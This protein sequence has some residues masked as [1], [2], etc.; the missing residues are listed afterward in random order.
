MDSLSQRILEQTIE[1]DN[2]NLLQYEQELLEIEKNLQQKEVPLNKQ[3]QVLQDF[4]SFLQHN[5]DEQTRNKKKKEILWLYVDYETNTLKN[6]IETPPT[7]GKPFI[8]YLQEHPATLQ[9][10][11][12]YLQEPET[13]ETWS[14]TIENIW[15]EFAFWAMDSQLQE[16]IK[17]EP[18][19]LQNMKT[20]LSLYFTDRLNG[21]SQSDLKKVSQV[22]NWRDGL[23]S[24]TSDLLW[25]FKNLTSFRE[26]MSAITFFTEG[27]DIYSKELTSDPE[28]NMSNLEAFQSP[29]GF[30]RLLKKHTLTP[31]SKRTD[32]IWLFETY[33]DINNQSQI[34]SWSIIEWLADSYT[35]NAHTLMTKVAILWPK[36]LES[37]SALKSTFW[38]LYDQI[39]QIVSIFN[40]GKPLSEVIKGS[41][42]EKPLNFIASILWFGSLTRYESRNNI[43][44]LTKKAP[45]SQKAW[46]L[47]AIDFV[48]QNDSPEVSEAFQKMFN[49][50]KTEDYTKYNITKEQVI[51]Q[52]PSESVLK[53]GI[54]R[55][56]L[57]DQSFFIHPKILQEISINKSEQYY[58]TDEKGNTILNPQKISDYQKIVKENLTTIC[59]HVWLWKKWLLNSDTIVSMVW[60]WKTKEHITSYLLTWL[61]YPDTALDITQKNIS[62][63]KKEK[64]D[65]E[66]INIQK[67]KNGIFA[68][69]SKN[70]KDPYKAENPTSSA[71]GKYQFLWNTRKEKITPITGISDKETYKNS[72]EQQEKFMDYV[73]QH[74][75][76]PTAKK[77]QVQ[78][79]N[80]KLPEL[81]MLLHFKWE[82]GTLDWIKN[83]VDK[84]TA[85]NI[86]ID[87][88]LNNFQKE[89]YA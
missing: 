25:V 82:A 33:F 69:E 15:G 28:K 75:H 79:P 84:T 31:W 51:A 66:E 88:Y 72:P 60:E 6:S 68:N 56:L 10:I 61:V 8:E 11:E 22:G 80:R 14:T 47:Q 16:K 36:V 76:I 39:S 83:E 13:I 87:K 29:E 23:L 45:E 2:P 20:G 42:F 18:A 26:Q 73:I 71:V 74:D 63:E 55:A 59:D 34:N 1:K 32:Q 24:K 48:E 17:N 77:L 78:Y 64:E 44:N 35:D 19:L 41:W 40:D 53:K 49:E 81:I 37:R 52:L 62:W 58:T 30:V 46:L 50:T 85:N 3:Q 70:L 5:E 65:K 7:Y 89:Y 43:K 67:I 21:L 27:M 4:L 54:E 57:S 38:E 86:S 12:S 9:K